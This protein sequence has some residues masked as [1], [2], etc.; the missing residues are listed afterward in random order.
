[1]IP[2]LWLSFNDT[3]AKCRWDQDAVLMVCP[4]DTY[5]HHFTGVSDQPPADTIGAVV[6]FAA[7]GNEKYVAELNAYLRNLEW[8]VLILTSDEESN[9]PWWRVVHPNLRLWI[10]TPRADK[11][12]GDLRFLPVGAPSPRAFRLVEPDRAQFRDVYFS[13]QVNHLQRENMVTHMSDIPD[14][15]SEIVPSPGFTLGLERNEYLKTLATAKV[16][17]CPS[18]PVSADS[19][20]TWEALEAGAVPIVDDGPLQDDL[21][22]AATGYPR[23]FWDKLLGGNR[24]FGDGPWVPVTKDW[25]DAPAIATHVV[26]NFPEYNNVVSFKYQRYKDSLRR[27]MSTDVAE[28]SGVHST[29]LITVLIPT[30]PTLSNPDFSHL[31]A[32]VESVRERLPDTRIILM[33]DGVRDEQQSFR[34][35]YE[36]YQRRVL[37]LCNHHWNVVPLRFETHHHQVAMT[38][39][40]LEE[41]TTPFILFVEHDTPLWG[42]IPWEQCYDELFSGR[43]DV[44]RFYHEAVLQEQHWH[45]FRGRQGDFVRTVQWSQRPHI[46]TTDYYRKMLTQHFSANAKSMIE[47]RLHGVVQDQGWDK[48]RITI[49]APKGMAD[50]KRSGHLDAR[51]SE[52]KHSMTF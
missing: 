26:K 37:W 8:V 15:R 46:S 28:L 18:G 29:D 16:V 31:E 43:A 32:T 5:T 30:S 23:G 25:S 39:R 10:Q 12:K 11:H 13:G 21:G 51:G 27:Q 17:C 47:D 2:V 24:L 40:A 44:V 33:L 7:G 19:F 45:L 9:F 49:Y 38:R 34:Q 6:T 52:P 42:D 4:E 50:I 3:P 22:R 41:V 14:L 20:R 35:H 36:E 1:M 48:N